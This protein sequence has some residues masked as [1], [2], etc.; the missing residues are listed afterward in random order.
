MFRG[1]FCSIKA[2]IS[3]GI[4][5]LMCISADAQP[6]SIGAS[7]SY[8]GMG[9]LYEHDFRAQDSFLEICVKAETSDYISN[10]RNYPGI[11]A[12]LSWNIIICEWLSSEGNTMRFFA[13][14]GVSVG[15]ISDRNTDEGLFLG[16]KGRVGGE[17]EFSR[18]VL[19]SLSISPLIASHF[20]MRNGELSMKYYRNGLI[21]GWVPEIGIKYRF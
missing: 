1:G 9:I 19:I 12:G 17:C 13:G 16:L 8:T 15:Y 3:A 6:K 18:N 11:S 7:F 14:P 2:I 10:R 20:V 4:M 5:F 21:Y